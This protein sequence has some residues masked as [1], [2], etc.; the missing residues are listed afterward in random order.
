MM[1]RVATGIGALALCVSAAACPKPNV[2]SSQTV[3]RAEDEARLRLDSGQYAASRDAF[4][5]MLELARTQ[6]DSAAAI[7]GQAFAEQ[8]TIESDSIAPDVADR[9]VGQYQLAQRLDSGGY[10]AAA[11]F[12]TALLLAS[13]GRHAASA[14]TYLRAGRADSALRG[15][16]FLAAARELRKAGRTTDAVVAARE[17]ET[18]STIRT[19]AQ[20]LLVELHSAMP[21]PSALVAL[22]DSLQSPSA[23]LATV[24]EALTSLMQDP[25]WAGSLWIE[26]CLLLLVRNLALL[27]IGPV[28]FAA[29]QRT[30]L[31]RA[32]ELNANGEIGRAMQAVLEAYRPRDSMAIYEEGGRS[33]WWT[34]RS[35]DDRRRTIWS[36]ALRGLG[37]WYNRA[38]S[39]RVA[40]SFYESA[41]GRPTYPVHEEWVDPEALLPL[42]ALYASL[43]DTGA[44]W[45]RIDRVEQLTKA[46]FEG[47]SAVRPGNTR[48][49][50]LIRLTLG[51]LFAR[52][53]RWD[54]AWNGA[55]YQLEETRRLTQRLAAETPGESTHL[56]P[57]VYERLFAEYV[58]RGCSKEALSIAEELHAEYVHRSASADRDRISA[59]ITRLRQ[60]PA[61]ATGESC[62]GAS[63]RA[64][65]G[66]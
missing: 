6:R 21:E 57:D 22:A 41:L 27:D 51:A 8:Q 46:L 9:L 30:P 4:A 31:E 32:A 44:L 29:T 15:A 52:Q 7:F 1:I 11:E 13:A 62:S 60:S 40:I 64:V 54:N 66:T 49:L 42:P 18:D 23:P 48:R 35:R 34:Q 37:D 47:K 20:A 65:V 36:R 24:N 59:E 55:I 3:R 33:S 39:A 53:G 58:K 2:A 12:N 25:R 10:H 43:P 61:T 63:R 56:P 26:Q 14:T 16:A 38:G 50:R 19:E 28:D 5:V 17:A 45:D